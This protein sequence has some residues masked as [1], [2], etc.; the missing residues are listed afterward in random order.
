MFNISGEKL[1]QLI[2]AADINMWAKFKPVINPMANTAVQYNYQAGRWKNASELRGA[3]PWWRSSINTAV[4]GIIPKEVIG[5][6]NLPGAYDGR[7]NGWQYQKPAGGQNQLYRLSDFAHYNHDA[8]PPISNFYI[9]NKIV[10]DG[11]FTASA[12]M[13][14]DDLNSD[15]LTLADFSSAAFDTLYFGVAFVSNGAVAAKC[16]ADVQGVAQ[17]REDFGNS[18]NMLPLYST[19]DVIPFF[20]DTYIPLSDTQAHANTHFY[21]VP[22][23]SAMQTQIVSR[24]DM[25]DVE[26]VAKYRVGSYTLID[27]EIDG[28]QNRALQNCSWYIIPTTYWG[29]PGSGLSAAVASES[30]GTI[31]IGGSYTKFNVNVQQGSYFLYVLF[32]NGTYTRKT[33]I[34]ESIPSQ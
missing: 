32:E 10:Q 31:A 3:A 15:Y 13:S 1:G 8:P 26:V 14:M 28:D 17:V 19:Y 16:T 2:T 30:I 6:L 21:T 9:Q 29:N 12:M 5:L 23:V 4:G 11:H 25:I 22:N 18:G 33:N 24:N 20:T 34:V 7:L 27:I